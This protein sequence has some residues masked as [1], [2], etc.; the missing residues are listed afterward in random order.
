MLRD[1]FGACSFTMFGMFFAPMSTHGRAYVSRLMSHA[2]TLCPRRC[3]PPDGSFGFCGVR[4]RQGDEIVL[5]THGQTTGFA[6]DPI[7]KKPLY[8]FHPGSKI[9]SFGSI[10]CNFSCNFCQNFRT[11]QSRDRS[12]LRQTASPDEIVRITWETGCRSVAFTYNEPII[13]AEY[14]ADVAAACRK[15][16]IKT[17][18]VS[19]GFI[20]PEKRPWFF[21]HIDAANI[22]L[23]SFSDEFYQEQC[24]ASLEPVKETLTYLAKSTNVWLEVTTLLIPGLNDSEAEMH[25]LST[26]MRRNLGAETP[27]HLSA[28]RP[29]NR[30]RDIP[31]TS[32]STLFHAREIAMRTGL[33]YVYTGNVSDP[34]G[35]T[36]LC[37]QCRQAIIVRSGF[38]IEEYAVDEEACCR[39]CG[40]S[41]AI[42][43]Q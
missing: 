35:G 16:G 26:W 32:P 27:L 25:E 30:L 15:A 3:S 41:I 23:K 11:A 8:H 21:E 38:N 10:G 39:F 29:M 9:L 33:R 7:E 43:V 5:T 12:L 28:F 20:T 17:V 34:A 4:Q 6:V 14:A 37:P 24:G 1:V 42:K 13:W 40:Q 18:A 19:N 36:T 22:D 31:S 2:C